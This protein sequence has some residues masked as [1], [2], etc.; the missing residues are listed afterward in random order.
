MD[1]N[2]V[3]TNCFKISKDKLGIIHR[4]ILK[5][6]H[7]TMEEAKKC[8]EI[9]IAMDG[10]GKMLMLVDARQF[11]TMAPEAAE[12]LKTIY[13]INR[14]ATAI[15]SNNLSEKITAGYIAQNKENK[16]EIFSS[17]E[18]AVKWLLAQR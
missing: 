14:I 7:I 15:V 10:G 16:L 4:E 8:E 5:D 6:A 18:E 1:G 17:E 9:S 2:V 12:Y 13:N 3:T 11:Y